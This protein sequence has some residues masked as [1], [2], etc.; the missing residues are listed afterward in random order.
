M[1]RIKGRLA[2]MGSTGERF[3]QDD[4]EERVSQ[5]GMAFLIQEAQEP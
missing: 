1:V 3:R 5:P 4:R 2:D